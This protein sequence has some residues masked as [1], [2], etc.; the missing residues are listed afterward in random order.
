SGPGRALW[1]NGRAGRQMT[2]AAVR[3]EALWPRRRAARQ[4][5][6][7]KVP[8]H[9]SPGGS[10]RLRMKQ[11][12]GSVAA[13][14]VCAAQGAVSGARSGPHAAQTAPVRAAETTALLKKIAPYDALRAEI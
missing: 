5:R 7:R 6:V 3:A 4:A 1:R 12:R 13:G 2:G 11:G 14:R 8:G 10:Q 9:V